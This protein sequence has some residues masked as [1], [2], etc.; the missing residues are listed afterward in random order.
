MNHITSCL[1]GRQGKRAVLVFFK[2]KKK[3]DEFYASEAVSSIRD[4]VIIL[5]EGVD[6]R[7][8][9][10]LIKRVTTQGQVSYL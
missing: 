10:L 6:A 8:K 4:S 5:T 7:E 1:T 9:Q 2:S 3:L